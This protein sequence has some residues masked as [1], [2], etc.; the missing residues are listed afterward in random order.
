MRTLAPQLRLISLGG[1]T[2]AA[3]WSIFHPIDQVDPAWRSIPYGKPLA[4]QRFYV[5]NEH[6]EDCPDDIPGELY[7]GGI[8]IA[9]GY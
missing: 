5:L 7:I 6:L 8:G 9:E 2:E 1:A 4:N 3:I